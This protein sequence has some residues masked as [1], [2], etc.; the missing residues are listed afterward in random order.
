MVIGLK[1]KVVNEWEIQ[2]GQ[3]DMWRHS[4]R[5]RGAGSSATTLQMCQRYL[6]LVKTS[7]V[8]QAM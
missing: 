2:A 6:L 4:R 5:S 7:A 3:P 1:C 8:K